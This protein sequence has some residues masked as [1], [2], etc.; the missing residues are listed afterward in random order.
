M[1][2]CAWPPLRLL[3]SFCRQSLPFLIHSAPHSKW[4]DCRGRNYKRASRYRM[5][6]WVDLL[7]L[8]AGAHCF[9]CIFPI[10][11]LLTLLQCFPLQWMYI[12]VLFPFFVVY[13]SVRWAFQRTRKWLGGKKPKLWLISLVSF[14][15]AIP[16]LGREVMVT[17]FPI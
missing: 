6:V 7:W 8:L 13:P 5:G 12:Q 11:G 10:V 14:K 17:W 1:L 9:Q 15:L 16:V 4:K 2:S 3:L